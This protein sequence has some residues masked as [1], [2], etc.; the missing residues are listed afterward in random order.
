MTPQSEH[1][2]VCVILEGEKAGLWLCF[3]LESLLLLMTC[4]SPVEVNGALMSLFHL[5]QDENAAAQGVLAVHGGPVCHL[6]PPLLQGP[7][8]RLPAAGALGSIPQH[9]VLHH[10]DRLLL[11]GEGYGHHPAQPSFS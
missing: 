3:Y 5:F 11:E 1:W 2:Q 7:P 10:G 9:Q 8:L 6:L 4:A